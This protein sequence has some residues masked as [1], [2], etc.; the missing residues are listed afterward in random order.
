MAVELWRILGRP[1]RL[2]WRIYLSSPLLL[3][4]GAA[5]LGRTRAS[6]VLSMRYLSPSNPYYYTV[7]GRIHVYQAI[8]IQLPT[9]LPIR[10]PTDEPTSSGIDERISQLSVHLPRA[11]PRR[12][13][14]RRHHQ[15]SGAVVRR[16]FCLFRP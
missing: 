10:A 9:A 12:I 1:C 16:A 8:A 15:K 13:I 14:A 7:G 4:C 11:R 3:S 2:S 5:P 6:Q